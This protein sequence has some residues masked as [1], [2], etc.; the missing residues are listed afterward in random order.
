MKNFVKYIY[1]LLPFML[2][3]FVSNAQDSTIVTTETFTNV[4]A[5]GTEGGAK[6]YWSLDYAEVEKVQNVINHSLVEGRGFL[7]NF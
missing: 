1:L 7:E 5:K 6:I 4:T 3:G 2:L